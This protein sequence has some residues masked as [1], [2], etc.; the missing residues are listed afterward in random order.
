MFRACGLVVGVNENVRVDELNGH[1]GRP[2]SRWLDLVRGVRHNNLILLK[3]PLVTKI[4]DEE[5]H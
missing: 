5:N 2:A 1:E 3:N 4:R